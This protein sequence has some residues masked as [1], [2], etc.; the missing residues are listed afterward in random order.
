MSNPHYRGIP[1]LTI[2][3]LQLLCLPGALPP[4]PAA[5][6]TQREE[7][8]KCRHSDAQHAHL[9]ALQEGGGGESIMLILEAS[10]KLHITTVLLHT[11]RLHQP[12]R[13][14]HTTQ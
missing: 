2:K 4:G 10:T 5:H 9:G 11:D 8:G 13:L 1:Q 3:L 14:S 6:A 7:E 12:Q